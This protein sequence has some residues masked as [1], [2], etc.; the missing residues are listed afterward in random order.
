M[1]NCYINR[2]NGH[3]EEWYG[4]YETYIE[5]LWGIFTKSMDNHVDLPIKC[6][7]DQFVQFVYEHS[8]GYIS[9][10]A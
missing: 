2:Q 4:V 8:S 6:N 5:T 9:E 10:Y 7:Y 3:F 1:N